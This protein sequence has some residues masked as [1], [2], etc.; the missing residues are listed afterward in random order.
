ME[1]IL[2]VRAVLRSQGRPINEECLFSEEELLA[3]AEL[4]N[5]HGQVLPNAR[6]GFAA[7]VE[8]RDARLAEGKA[9]AE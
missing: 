4:C 6:D 5:D 8:V 3:L 7:I 1:N 9:T 2:K